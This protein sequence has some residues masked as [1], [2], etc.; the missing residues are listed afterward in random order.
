MSSQEEQRWQNSKREIGR[1]KCRTKKSGGEGVVFP[2]A[3]KKIEKCIALKK[4]PNGEMVR[5]LE[6]H[7]GDSLAKGEKR[8]KVTEKQA[9]KKVL[10]MSK[11]SIQV[12]LLSRGGCPQLGGKKNANSKATSDQGVKGGK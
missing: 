4:P 3:G 12:C 2:C 5:P 10:N 1:A 6:T 9:S 7:G 11:N 8:K